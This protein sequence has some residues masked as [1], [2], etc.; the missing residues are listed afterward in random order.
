MAGRRWRRG[1]PLVAVAILDLS[2]KGE[3]KEERSKRKKEEREPGWQ[4]R[5]KQQPD[6]EEVKKRGRRAEK[7]NTRRGQEEKRQRERKG[8]HR[9]YVD[10]T[11]NDV[12]YAANYDEEIKHIPGITKVPLHRMRWARG[13]GWERYVRRKTTSAATSQ[14]PLKW[15]EAVQWTVET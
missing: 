3:E 11:E 13:G 1:S 2:M 9:T 12:Y 4:R 10:L 5:Q 8:G 7:R 6:T 14:P 15:Y